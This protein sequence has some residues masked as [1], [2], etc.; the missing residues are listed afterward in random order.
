MRLFISIA[1]LVFVA[2]CTDTAGAPTGVVMTPGLSASASSAQV[3]IDPALLTPNPVENSSEGT[4]WECQR[5]G[6]GARCTGHFADVL[7]VGDGYEIGSCG[8]QTLYVVSG[9]GSRDQVRQF[10]NDLLEVGRNV[11]LRVDDEILSLSLTGEGPR[12]VGFQNIL[13]LITFGVPGDLATRSRTES[14]VYLQE[15]DPGGRVVFQDTGLLGY[16]DS[17]ELLLRHG[18]FDDPEGTAQV[19]LDRVCAWLLGQ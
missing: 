19:F 18:R 4:V 17:D 6:T 1:A 2:A 9:T 15:R 13:Q 12:L 10:N 11:H 3:S 7:R 14:G 8:D 5:I 16:S